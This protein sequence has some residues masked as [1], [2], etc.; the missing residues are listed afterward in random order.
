MLLP[1]NRLPRDQD[2]PET[3]PE[4]TAERPT[5]IAASPPEFPN[6]SRWIPA[7]PRQL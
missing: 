7:R 2:R 3:A 6:T 5:L 4:I 1:N